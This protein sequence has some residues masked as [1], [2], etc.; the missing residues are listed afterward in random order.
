MA[1]ITHSMIP[2][3]NASASLLVMLLVAVVVGAILGA[4]LGYAISPTWL[5]LICGLCGTLA[6]MYARNTIIN[7]IAG[8]GP[9]DFNVPS[10]VVVYALIAAVAGSLAAK[11]VLDH[12][13]SYV[14][15]GLLGAIAALFSA[16][17]M[18]M[19]MLTYYLNPHCE[20]A[21]R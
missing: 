15:T 5:A 19:L 18:G 16:I 7:R 3:R 1:D 2:E 20:D 21:R 9:N 11:E 6:A 17:L 12:A 13:A 4:I 8:V 10:V 14:S